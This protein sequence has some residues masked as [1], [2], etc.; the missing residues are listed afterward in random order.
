[1]A[2]QS[3][4]VRAKICLFYIKHIQQ[5]RGSLSSNILREI[6]S[7]LADFSTLAQV[8]CAFLRFF[9]CYTSSWGPEVLLRSQIRADATS[10]WLVLKDRRLFCSGGGTYHIGSHA[11][12]I[13]HPAEWKEAC[14]IS[15]D[16]MVNQLPNMLTA[17]FYHGIIEVIDLY[18]FGGGKL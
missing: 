16:G 14:L 2:S 6:S 12:S 17:R 11:F 1:M 18:V 8:T 13:S 9:N 15:L 10:R 7:Y 4:A 5:A 3:P